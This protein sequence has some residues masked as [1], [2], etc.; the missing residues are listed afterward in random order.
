[1]TKQAPGWRRLCGQAIGKRSP[2]NDGHFQKR[3]LAI[4]VLKS[5]FGNKQDPCNPSFAVGVMERK[6]TG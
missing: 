3:R 2:Q 1:M 6:P 5:M 4:V